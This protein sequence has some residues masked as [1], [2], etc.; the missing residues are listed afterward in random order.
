MAKDILEVYSLQAFLV[1]VVTSDH[2]AVHLKT[3][4]KCLHH[5]K[6][7]RKSHYSFSV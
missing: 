2:I 5:R 4:I 3:I 1:G 6:E 7:E